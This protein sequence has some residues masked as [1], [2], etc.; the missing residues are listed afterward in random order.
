[1]TSILPDHSVSVHS[2]C[3]FWLW[4]YLRCYHRLQCSSRLTHQERRWRAGTAKNPPG[5]RRRAYLLLREGQGLVYVIVVLSAA[6]WALCKAATTALLESL[7]D[8]RAA[9]ASQMRRSSSAT[10]SKRYLPATRRLA[11][12]SRTSSTPRLSTK[13]MAL[14]TT[15]DMARRTATVL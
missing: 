4:P 8:C 7:T 6:D 5:S 11:S 10:R 3:I 13:S 1:M 12:S 14:R 9:F 2:H 15:A